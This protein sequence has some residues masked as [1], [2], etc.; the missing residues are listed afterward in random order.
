[1]GSRILEPKNYLDILEK[2]KKILSLEEGINANYNEN[3][4]VALISGI[5]VV[6]IDM[7]RRFLIEKDNLLSQRPA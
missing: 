6:C 2:K 7:W 1:M 4:G 5:S 3:T